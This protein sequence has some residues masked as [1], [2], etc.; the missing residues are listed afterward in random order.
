M[1]KPS[2]SDTHPSVLSPR[3]VTERSDVLQGTRVSVRDMST[4]THRKNTEFAS[5]AKHRD[6]R[7][8]GGE[9]GWSPVVNA[10]WALAFVRDL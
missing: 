3:L 1:G 9:L 4:A 8:E 5:V 7:I 2:S 10:D 6:V